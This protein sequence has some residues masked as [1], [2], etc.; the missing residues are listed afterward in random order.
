MFNFKEVISLTVLLGL[1]SCFSAAQVNQPKAPDNSQQVFI[2]DMAT[3]TKGASIS[4]IMDFN[5]FKTKDNINGVVPKQVSDIATAKLYLTTSNT[6][7]LN[8]AA[9]KFTSNLL[10]FTGTAKTYTFQ[11]VPPGGPYFVGVELFDTGA[12]N[13]VEPIAYGGTT[14]T[15]GLTVSGNPVP[16]VTVDANALTSHHNALTINPILKNGIGAKIETNITPENGTF[17]GSVIAF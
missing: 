13:I 8:A 17:T 6:D 14:G 16:S 4:I 12:A 1:T 2:S 11:N 9:L 15:R 5:S 7:P 10:T 3:G